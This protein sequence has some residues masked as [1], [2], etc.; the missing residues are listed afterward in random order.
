MLIDHFSPQYDVRARY[1]IAVRA[2]L[3]RVYRAAREMDLRGSRLARALFRLRG[4]PEKNLALEGMLRWG[5]VLLADE[6]ELEFVLGLA[7]RFL[8]S[9]PADPI[10][11]GRG[12]CRL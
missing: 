6:P 7:G 1:E 3:P 10:R 9:F 8:D 4:L 2:P 12:F 5:F 11:E